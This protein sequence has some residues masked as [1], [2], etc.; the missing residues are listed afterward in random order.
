MSQ[1]SVSYAEANQVNPTHAHTTANAE[2]R[3]ATMPDP[4]CPSATA[5][6][7]FDP[8]IENATTIVRS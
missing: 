1:S 4:I 3:N 5:W 6:A 7:K 2:K 8:E